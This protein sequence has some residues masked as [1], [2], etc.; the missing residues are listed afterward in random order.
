MKLKDG[1]MTQNVDDVQFLVPI[2]AENFSGLVRSNPTAAFIVDQLKKETTPE[3]I[4]EAMYAEY[5][6]PK[7]IL[8]KDVLKVLEILRGIHALDE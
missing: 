8:K 1:F 5:D 6:A 4:V 7:D 2:A 3:E